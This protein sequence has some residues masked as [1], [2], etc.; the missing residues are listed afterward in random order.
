MLQF[1]YTVYLWIF[2]IWASVLATFLTAVLT[3]LTSP[4]APAS[5]WAHAIPKNWAKLV[6][7]LLCVRVKVSGIEN[8]D[9]RLSCVYVSNHQSMI[10]IFV[11]YGYLPSVFKW[12]MKSDLIK[13]PF[14]GWACKAA[15]H[16]F[17]NRSTALEAKRSIE[18]AEQKLRG[19]VS[20]VIFPE[21]SRTRDG[22]MGT[23]K[24][25]AFR[26]AEDLK[27]PIVPVTLSGSYERLPRNHGPKFRYGTV[28]MFIHPPIF[29]DTFEQ[30]GETSL[31]QQTWKVVNAPLT[32]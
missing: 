2:G 10:D 6:C 20:V 21:G 22:R 24:K 12:I 29:P 14:V 26:I 15:G 13:I 3:M 30:N 1:I 19:G 28:Q 9:S 27:L 16:V 23:F 5:R 4:F 31:M 7:F 18:E 11:I 32:N 25:G 8:A 17:I